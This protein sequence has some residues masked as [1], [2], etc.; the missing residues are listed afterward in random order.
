[1]AYL[2]VFLWLCAVCVVNAQTA[3]VASTTTRQCAGQLGQACAGDSQ[4][5]FDRLCILANTTD[6]IFDKGDCPPGATFGECY[7]SKFLHEAECEVDSDCPGMCERCGIA[8]DGITPACEEL[9]ESEVRSKATRAPT[10]TVKTTT[11]ETSLAK[12]GGC[13]DT[14][15]LNSLGGCRFTH[16]ADYAAAVLC[17]SGICMTPSHVVIYDGAEMKWENFLTNTDQDYIVEIRLVNNCVPGYWSNPGVDVGEFKVSIT[18]YSGLGYEFAKA[19]DI[20][21]YVAHW[22]VG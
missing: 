10:T 19:Y 3:V 1:M 9:G 7:C 8:T 4:C 6:A 5:K 11:A 22:W 18:A 16:R 13:V 20:V 17:S 15:L 21:S 12:I 14:E 2:G